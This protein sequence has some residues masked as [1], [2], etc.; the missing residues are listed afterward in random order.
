[1]RCYHGV[2]K[3]SYKKIIKEKVIKSHSYWTP[4]EG[5]AVTM[6]GPYVFIREFPEITD[7]WIGN[8]GWEYIYSDDI[9]LLEIIAITKHNIKL[10]SYNTELDEKLHKQK[11]LDE[12]K[13]FCSVCLGKEELTYLNNGHHL[14]PSGCSFSHSKYKSRWTKHV[15]SCPVCGL[16]H[17]PNWEEILITIEKVEK[18]LKEKF[19]AYNPKHIKW[20]IKLWTFKPLKRSTGDKT[21]TPIIPLLVS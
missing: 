12:G 1:M 18:K 3:K 10:I 13:E 15:V 19:D 16:K 11:I 17:N 14:K 20:Y 7:E 21:S 4:F 8:G 5:D 6:G 9:L 2:T